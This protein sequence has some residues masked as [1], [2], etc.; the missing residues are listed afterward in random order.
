MRHGQAFRLIVAFALIVASPGSG[1]GQPPN[2]TA[3][4]GAPALPPGVKVVRDL[5]YVGA[6]LDQQKLDLYLPES[7]RELLPLVVWVHGGGWESNSKN[8]C[9]PALELP[10]RGYALASINY[11]LTDS[12]PFP[13]QIED[14][15]AAVRWLR[16]HA[17]EYQ[18][19]PDRVG[20]WGPSAGGH[21][22]ALLGTAADQTHWDKVGRHAAIST[23]LQAVCDYY[24]PTDFLAAI[25]AG[26]TDRA[27]ARLL[28]G[29]PAQK[30]DV[31]R[32]ASPVTYVSRDDCPFL[33]VHGDQDP[34][35][36]LEQSQILFERLKQ[37]R[38]DA[39]I[40]VVK[41]GKHGN[42]G[43]DVEPSAHQIR[44][45]V[46]SFFDQHRKGGTTQLV[47]K[48]VVKE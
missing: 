28:G 45:S 37:A 26:I 5:D 2:P 40:L 23:R 48:A 21:L 36:P 20:A 3:G 47:P 31:A 29:P 27:D 24:G 38:L 12:G 13:T 18:V 8:N 30:L 39:T 16:V 46:F 7:T 1:L 32:A 41:H 9:L 22:V 19:N 6:G 35:V 4:A 15:R 25:R 34:T 10:T 14:C 11:R 42:W 17:A 33:I 44:E 43:P